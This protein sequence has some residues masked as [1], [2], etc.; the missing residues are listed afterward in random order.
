MDRRP[1]THK[2]ENCFPTPD[3]LF[4]ALQSGYGTSTS[5]EPRA[6]PA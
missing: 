3:R 1:K 6:W 5:F 2:L 4:A